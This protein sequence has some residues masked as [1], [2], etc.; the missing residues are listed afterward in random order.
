MRPVTSN[1][2]ITPQFGPKRQVLIPTVKAPIID[3]AGIFRFNRGPLNDYDLCLVEDRLD[4]DGI[5]FNPRTKPVPY[6]AKPSDRYHHT[7]PPWLDQPPEAKHFQ[8]LGTLPVAGNFTG[9]DIVLQ[10]SGVS[11]PL[12]VCDNGYD[13]IITDLVLGIVNSGSTGFTNASGQIIWRVGVDYGQ[14][15]NQALW[16]YRD[17]GNVIV[18]IGSLESPTQVAGNGGLRFISGQAISIFVNL[19]TASAGIINNNS[20]IIGLIGGYTYPR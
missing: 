20:T 18:S 7:L 1:F 17:Y 5:V 2:N 4:W 11:G 15:T 8:R 6:C 19:P 3:R 16:Y 9:T 13:G 10:L 14:L 12:F